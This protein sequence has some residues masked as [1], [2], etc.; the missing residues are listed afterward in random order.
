M[1]YD[2]TGN[3]TA[4]VTNGPV[5]IGDV[6][7]DFAVTHARGV[8]MDAANSVW[9][10]GSLD[11]ST[12]SSDRRWS[13]R[14]LLD[15]VSWHWRFER[16]AAQD[17]VFR[18]NAGDGIKLS[19]GA[20][21]AS[22][23]L[24]AIH[25]RIAAAQEGFRERGRSKAIGEW[26]TVPYAAN[27]FTASNGLTWTV[28]ETN[29]KTYRYARVGT[30]VC[31]AVTVQTTVVSG[32]GSSLMVK[33]PEGLVSAGTFI[34]PAIIEQSAQILGYCLVDDG[35]E[36][37]SIRKPD[38]SNWVASGATKAHCAITLEHR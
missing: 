36:Y 8:K 17:Y 11:G 27:L 15:V 33:L 37:V 20:D 7:A 30:T 5:T 32:S 23:R 28:G 18:P 2:N 13:W 24:D 38:D 31:L 16:R 35:D 3:I 21:D 34:G 9:A 29:V 12:P 19:F 22:S 26:R 25:T 4:T 1:S 10:V 6:S 14:D